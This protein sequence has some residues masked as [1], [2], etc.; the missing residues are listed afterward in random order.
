M[1]TTGLYP[2]VRV[3]AVGSGVVSQAGALLL[4]DAV[5]ESGLDA[6]LS[7]ALAPWRKPLA[8]HDPARIVTDLAI[9]LGLGGDC[10][11]DIAVLRAEPAVFGPVASDPTVS[12]AID[13][14][15]G[16]AEPVLAAINAAR[17]AAR[18]RV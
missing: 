13:M 12:R 18:A 6:E 15:A 2:R 4:T 14:L 11:S 10:M 7:R 8:V 3:D 17:A 16:D 5:R 1:K 9:M